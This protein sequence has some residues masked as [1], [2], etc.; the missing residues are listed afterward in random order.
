[1][2]LSFEVRG[3]GKKG[4]PHTYHIQIPPPHSHICPV[5]LPMLDYALGSAFLL[6]IGVYGH[7]GGGLDPQGS[8][9]RLLT[10]TS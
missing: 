10:S 1:M 3:R 4:F 6:R 2:S 9:T 5:R 7:R 8:D